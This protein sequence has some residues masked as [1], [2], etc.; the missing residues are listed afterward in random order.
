MT[1]QTFSPSIPQTTNFL[2][3][4]GGFIFTAGDQIN[5]VYQHKRI[6]GGLRVVAILL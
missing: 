5:A 2:V 1:P 4:A 6:T 3:Y